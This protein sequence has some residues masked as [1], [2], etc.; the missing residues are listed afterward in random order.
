MKMLRY[1][2]KFFR[3]SFVTLSFFVLSAAIN[4]YGQAGNIDHPI[5]TENIRTYI[6]GIK[7]K[8]DQA[9]N[10]A[11][12]TF[13]AINI[14]EAKISAK[15]TLLLLEEFKEIIKN[16]QTALGILSNTENIK[17]GKHFNSIASDLIDLHNKIK[18]AAYNANK[19]SSTNESH[20]INTLAAE[21]ISESKKMEAI[22]AGTFGSLEMIDQE[23]R[24]D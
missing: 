20:A 16:S 10:S 1:S 17:C 12:R 23:L 19:I 8:T 18:W 21:V 6:Y 4:L 5:S 11:Q 2:Y 7:E 15:Q 22:V 24:T 14:N 9:R 3:H 13:N